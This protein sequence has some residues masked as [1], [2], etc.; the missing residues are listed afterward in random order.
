[1]NNKTICYGS[2]QQAFCIG[3]TDTLTMSVSLQSLKPLAADFDGKSYDYYHL[4]G[5]LLKRY[6]A[7]VK[8]LELLGTS[9]A[10]NENFKLG[11][12]AAKLLM[13]IKRNVQRL[14][15]A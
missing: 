2:I 11:Q 14:S 12:S 10:A 7:V 3:Y 13:K 9:A 6:I 1:M 4:N 8:A 15:K 5:S